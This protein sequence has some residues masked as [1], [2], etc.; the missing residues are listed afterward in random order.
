MGQMVV[1]SVST[2]LVSDN[3]ELGLSRYLPF[4]LCSYYPN[5][6]LS[7]SVYLCV[8]FREQPNWSG[9]MSVRANT[10]LYNVTDPAV[11]VRF[12]LAEPSGR[13][14]FYPSDVEELFQINKGIS[15]QKL[16]RVGGVERWCNKGPDS[17]VSLTNIDGGVYVPN[18]EP[19]TL[20]HF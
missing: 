1:E 3:V 5:F 2:R 4:T 8:W 9:L 17:S 18:P 13:H 14:R 19:K 16:C 6:Y 11:P 7:K 15:K 20:I 10:E 12:F